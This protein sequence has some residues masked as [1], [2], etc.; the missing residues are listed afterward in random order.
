M[1]KTTLTDRKLKALPP[2]KSGTRYEVMDSVVPGFGVRVTPSGKRTFVL[3]GRFG[4]SQNPTRR[5][6]GEDGA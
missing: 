3:V 1:A 6:L 5:A 4:G 2:A